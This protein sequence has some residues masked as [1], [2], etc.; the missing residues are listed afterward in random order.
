MLRCYPGEVSN[1]AENSSLASSPQSPK[2]VKLPPEPK[3][4]KEPKKATPPSSSDDD[5]SSS[6]GDSTSDDGPPKA[7]SSMVD[8]A[9]ERPHGALGS[10]V[11]GG[12]MAWD[13]DHPPRKNSPRKLGGISSGS[14][15]RGYI[16]RS[17]RGSPAGKKRDNSWDGSNI[18]QHFNDDWGKYSSLGGRN[19]LEQ[20]ATAG[21]S[22]KENSPT[23]SKHE[24]S[25]K[26]IDNPSTKNSPQVNVPVP[27]GHSSPAIIINVN[28]GAVSPASIPPSV[29]APTVNSWALPEEQNDKSD[30]K[31]SSTSSG[32]S[33]SKNGSDNFR[34][35]KKKES[36][37][38]NMPGGWGASNV[39]SHA[40]STS[41]NDNQDEGAQPDR[42]WN[43]DNDKQQENNN[44][45]N[46]NGES[47]AQPEDSWGATTGG[48]QETNTGWNN[49]GS[50]GN[51]ENQ[52]TNTG[53]NNNN[54]GNGEH[55]E[56]TGWGNNGNSENKDH[57]E[58]NNNGSGD[59]NDNSGWNNKGTTAAPTSGWSWGK[60]GTQNQKEEPQ[61]WGGATEKKNGWDMPK[62][63]NSEPEGKA[64]S[65]KPTGIPKYTMDF[66]QSP[67]VM[68]TTSQDKPADPNTWPSNAATLN[69]A[70]GQTP[71]LGT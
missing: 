65:E 17:Q 20:E 53:W 43:N 48:A 35:H 31:R 27:P 16:P 14:F 19:S 66:T 60:V 22:S 26:G 55:K 9:D 39:G 50:G 7:T 47:S 51:G 6:S 29:H 49:N 34:G 28:H 24:A 42:G 4:P 41:W 71:V 36:W 15:K 45:W 11:F 59:N 70:Q 44:G 63:D 68:S 1:S 52:E 30:E 69:N 32:S 54:N 62:K 8:G 61:T 3:S 13:D 38:M 23:L 5:S 37:A 46:N 2:K 40:N 57:G 64:T 12:D 58:W 18:S 21:R 33:G 56:N 10:L 25:P 67:N